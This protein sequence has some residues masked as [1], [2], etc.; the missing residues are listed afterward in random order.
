MQQ[1]KTVRTAWL[2]FMS[3]SIMAAGAIAGPIDNLQP[4]QWY[5]FPGTRIR[6]VLPSPIP[7]GNPTA[8][9]YYSGGAY[10]TRRNRL[11]VW[12]GGHAAYDGNE[13]YAFDVAAG[14]WSR[15]TEPTAEPP[16]VHSYDQLVVP[17]AAGSAVR[18]GWLGLG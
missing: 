8:M 16:S 12:G 1:H 11:I 7:Q 14:K 10:D 4:G 3:A 13:V 2:P 18:R 9:L 15:L 6:D 5:E 17:A